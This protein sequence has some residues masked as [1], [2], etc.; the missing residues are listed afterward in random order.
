MQKENTLLCPIPGFIHLQ[1]PR[2]RSLTTHPQPAERESALATE[3]PEAFRRR[4]YWHIQPLL[5]VAGGQRHPKVLDVKRLPHRV[6][7]HVSAWHK[8]SVALA[9]RH[10]YSPSPRNRILSAEIK[11]LHVR[12]RG[13]FFGTATV[14]SRIH[15]FSGRILDGALV[16]FRIL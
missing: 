3:T 13:E 15:G 9:A 16:V 8:Y 6:F 7:L 4:V 12:E 2:P 11:S 1:R 10:G 5:E 14:A